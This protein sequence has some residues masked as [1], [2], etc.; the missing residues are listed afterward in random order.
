MFADGLEIVLPL[1][2][3]K[4]LCII[5]AR[6]QQKLWMS[7]NYQRDLA[8]STKYL[9]PLP[10]LPIPLKKKKSLLLFCGYFLF[11]ANVPTN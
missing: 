7:L 3:S 6:F 5:P 11:D 8:Y 2:L 10:P 4:T 9:I 1:L